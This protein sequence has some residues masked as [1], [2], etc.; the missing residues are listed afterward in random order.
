[1]TFDE[2]FVRELQAAV[3]GGVKV[4]HLEVFQK[5]PSNSQFPCVVYQ[6]TDDAPEEELEENPGMLEATFSCVVIANNSASLRTIAEAIKTYFNSIT[7]IDAIYCETAGKIP[8]MKAMNDS[9]ENIFAM[10]QQE[11][12]KQ[13]TV[14][15]VAM[16]HWQPA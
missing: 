13:T 3:G 4:F 6:L 11:K 14:L 16:D 12:G 15:Q 1:M 10:E 8:W 2:Y 7:N 5:I 9:E